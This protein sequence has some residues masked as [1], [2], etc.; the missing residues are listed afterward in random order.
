MSFEQALA[1]SN[2]VWRQGT[3]I[4]SLS[5]DAMREFAISQMRLI[6]MERTLPADALRECLAA[7]DHL[8]APPPG[9]TIEGMRLET[10]DAIQQV[11][12]DDGRGGGRLIPQKVRPLV[13]LRKQH[14]INRLPDSPL[15]NVTGFYF[16]GRRSTTR[17]AECYHDGITRLA[18]VPPHRRTA[19]LF[20]DAAFL[21]A[22]SWSRQPLLTGMLPLHS[23]QVGIRDRHDTNVAGLR[24]LLAIEAYRMEDGSYPDRLEQV[25]PSIL[26]TVPVDPFSG[27]PFGYRRLHGGDADGRYYLLWSTGSD[28]TD[29]GGK[30]HPESNERAVAQRVRT[31]S[32][33]GLPEKPFVPGYDYIINE[34]RAKD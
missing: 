8:P 10:L 23:V 9:L 4:D 19:D 24:T 34:P 31:W 22:L 26:S 20:D 11:F 2:A 30:R 7:L 15:S 13:V 5:G 17:T 21:E 14:L 33:P 28:A 1:V 3:F 18:A 29:D 12:T 16:E 32:P 27:R 6:A 25:S